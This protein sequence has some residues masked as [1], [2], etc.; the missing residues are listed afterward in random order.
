MLV[1]R[2]GVGGTKFGGKGV[3]VRGWDPR[4]RN[5]R[6]RGAPGEGTQGDARLLRMQY[7]CRGRSHQPS[8]E[9][10]PNRGGSE[11][12]VVPGQAGGA[13]METAGH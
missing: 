11:P 10:V 4:D 5:R 13:P 7:K 2:K 8:A 1:R 9:D 3:N 6:V 12:G